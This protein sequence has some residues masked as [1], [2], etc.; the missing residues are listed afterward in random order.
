MKISARAFSA[1]AMIALAASAFAAQTNP[2]AVSDMLNRIGGQGT[3]D[4]FV[5]ILDETLD[6]KSDSETFVLTSQDGK[7]CIKGSTLSALTTGIGWYLNHNANINVS[8]N[9]PNPDLTTATLP[10]PAEETHST[11]TKYRYYLNYCTFS[12]SMS[13][14]TWDRWQQE[15]DWMALHGINMPLQIIGLEEVWRKF[16]MEDYGYTKDEVNSF[17]AGPGFMAW[18]GMNNLEGHGGPN[19][20][21]WYERQAQLGKQ[22]G[23]RMR[24]LGMEPVL[25]GFYQVPSN[26]AQKSGLATEGTGNWCGFSRPHLP[27][28]SN[29]SK[30]KEVGANYYKRL[31]EVLGESKYYSMDPFHEGGVG[32]GDYA[33]ALYQNLYDIM[34]TA[35]PGSQWVIQQWQWNSHQRKSLDAV[36]VGK[37]IVLDLNAER[38]PAYTSFK[39]HDTVFSTI[40]NFGART[41]FDGRFDGTING[42]FNALNTPSVKGIGAA[43][44]GIEQT[45]VAYDMLFEL[46]WLSEKPDPAKWMEQYTQSRYSAK[47]TE[48]QQAWELLRTS[49]LNMT[50]AVQPPHE[51]VFCAR[52]SLT[53]NKVSTWGN[54]DIFYNRSAVVDAAYKLLDANLS[55]LNYSFD[56]T[57]IARQALTDYGKQLIA[58]IKEANDGGNTEL[59]NLRRDALLQLMLDLDELLNTNKDFMLGHWT[60]RS[61]AMADEIA[62]TTNA[63]RDWLELDNAR[64]IITTWGK[65]AQA[66]G[67]GLHD[68]SYREWGGMLKDYYYQRWKTW[69]DNGMKEPNGGWFQWEWNWAHSNPNAYN[70]TPVGDTHDVALKVLPKYLS[71]FT[72]GLSDQEPLYIDRLLTTDKRKEFFDV[73]HPESSYTPNINGNATIS[74]IAIDT[75]RN[76]IFD[77]AETQT[78]ATYSISADTEVGERNV[79]L[80]LSD[81]TI[82]YYT[83]KIIVNITDPRTVS[84][85]SANAAQGSAEIVGAESASVTNTNVV[86]LLAKPAA[87][88]D[89]DHWTDAA[90]N[91]LGNDNPYNYYGKEAAEFTAHFVINK[92]G[93]PDYNGNASELSTMKSYKQ[94]INKMSLVQGGETTELYSASEC[95]ENHFIQIP[96]RIKAAPGSEF[97]FTY[98]QPGDGMKYLYLSAYVDLNNDGK[99]NPEDGELLGTLGTRNKQDNSVGAGTFTILLPYDA[100]KGTTHIRLRFDGAWNAGY[101]ETTKAF[102]ADAATNRIIYEI[103]LEVTDAA[104]FVSNVTVASSNIGLGTVRSE[105][106][107]T[108]LYAPGDEVVLTA[109]PNNSSVHVKRWIDSHGRELPEEWMSEGKLSVNFK[110][111]DNAAITCEFEAEPLEAN[112][113]KFNWDATE[114]GSAKLT[115]IIETGD[116]ELDLSSLK[117]AGIAP[118]IF[119]DA[120]ITG[121][122]LPATTIMGDGDVIYS[123][124]SKGSGKNNNQ[125]LVSVNGTNTTEQNTP[126]KGTSPWIFIINGETGSNSFNQ[127]GSVLFANGTD[128][129]ANS[130]ANGWSQFYLKKDGTL[131]IKWDSAAENKFDQ[132]NLLGNF[133]IRAEFDGNK[134][135]TVTASNAAGQSQTKTITNSSTMKNIYR[136]VNCIP[137]GMNLTYTFTELSS[138]ANIADIFGNIHALQNVN[139]PSSSA[140]Y[141]S[142]NGVLYN[143]AGKNVVLYPCGRLHAPFFLKNNT[144]FL[145][146]NPIQTASA[147]ADA[148][149]TKGAQNI[150]ALWMIN[151]KALT[152]LNSR[153]HLSADATKASA[154][155]GEFTHSFA[156]GTGMPKLK[157]GNHTFDFDV[158]EAIAVTA[159]GS[160]TLT[161]PVNVT[162]PAG[163]NVAKIVA[164]TYATGIQFEQLH[165]G[166]FIPACNPVIITGLNGATATFPIVEEAAEVAQ[167]NILKGTCVEIS[168]PAECFVLSGNNFVKL[169]AGSIPA[170]TAYILASDIP[171]EVGSAFPIDY[172]GGEQAGISGI[173]APQ[174]ADKAFDLMGRPTVANRPG[175]YIIN[176]V[177][178]RK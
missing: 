76:G 136:F 67:G 138:P 27:S 29:V 26:F 128:G 14:W 162:V 23:E 49:A 33:L 34:N 133:T 171:A 81:G 135:L 48:A 142:I 178:I 172:A 75:N 114:D 127:Y 103:Q 152:H 25:P 170:N 28:V 56:L 73:T 1:F 174:Q 173:N 54:G 149:I 144:D 126:L 53:V 148:E 60:K 150:G 105:N 65:Q 15:I 36:P 13:T 163:V 134:S 39:G 111:F 3:A 42:F 102:P 143:K 164:V 145:G 168:D 112:G 72:S 95:P 160:V 116:A 85:K 97:T 96:Q 161:L 61:R 79:K 38:V 123:E 62:G 122:T 41:G 12:Y 2:K 139:I 121:L 18:F 167:S 74:K 66:N 98:T 99:F 59:F 24:S 16:L 83:V 165:E 131:V 8:W 7:P 6:T 104:D 19:P 177:K 120:N 89:F 94:Y 137:E 117:I 17:V 22:M 50:S 69:F 151:D 55:G 9:N 37:L 52:P 84:V 57:D 35:T 109:F 113:W 30:L 64:T 146:A 108:N 5:T 92:W 40:F 78:G 176:G 4:R 175:I 158:A 93:V 107:T 47:S 71:K 86:S 169:S 51:A 125:L 101:D 77:E 46:P 82:L 118:G 100:V 68:Y 21:W 130:Y 70:D 58:G 110:A 159:A 147:V 31:N 166:D 20:D 11:T 10:L 129:T 132:V 87:S 154:T 63:D 88:Y 106:E 124:T 44:E 80:E 32:N 155:K 156:Y 45:P 91:N 43:P 141:K 157:L 115:S 153:L 119:D 90:G 140:N